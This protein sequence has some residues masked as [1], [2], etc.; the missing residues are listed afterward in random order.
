ME[1]TRRSRGW[2]LLIV[3]GA[4]LAVYPAAYMPAYARKA[5]ARLA[6]VN[7]TP[8]PSTTTPQW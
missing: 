3:M 6:I 1:A 5:G 4:T 2:D 8:I 7:L